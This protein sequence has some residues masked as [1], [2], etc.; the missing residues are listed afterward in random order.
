MHRFYLHAVPHI[1]GCIILHALRRRTILQHD[2]KY[3][4]PLF[5]VDTHTQPS[6]HKNLSRVCNFCGPRRSRS[7]SL[8]MNNVAALLC[9]VACDDEGI[10][11]YSSNKV[12][13]VAWD[14]R[15]RACCSM[16]VWRCGGMG[17]PYALPIIILS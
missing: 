2:N 13:G 15:S 14:L 12:D 17:E 3:F 5:H 4:P 1:A 9:L 10:I 16:E 11:A 8:T 7:Q 6:F